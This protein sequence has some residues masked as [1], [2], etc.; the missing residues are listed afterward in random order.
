MKFHE[1]TFEEYLI[2]NKKITLHPKLEKLYKSLPKNIDNLKNII[3]FGP[4]GVGK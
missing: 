1:T 3:F 4:S 2:S